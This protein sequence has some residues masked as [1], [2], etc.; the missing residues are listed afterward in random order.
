MAF[1]ETVSAGVPLLKSS[2]IPMRH[3]FT[4]RLGGVSEGY[5]ASLNLGEH[6]GDDPECVRENYRRLAAAL[7]FDLH[8]LVYTKQLHGNIVQ[9]VTSAD[10][11]E[12][13]TPL[14]TERDGICTAEPDLPLICYT[15]DC[16]PIL[17]CEPERNLAAAVHSGW[18]S[19]VRDIARSAVGALAS[20]GAEPEKLRAAIGP[21]IGKCCF[22]VGSDVADAMRA[23]LGSEAG[24][25]LSPRPDGKFLAD[26]R[27]ASKLRLMQLGLR[28]ENIDVSDECTMCSPEK[29]WSHRVTKGLRGSQAAVIIP[30]RR[31]RD[32]I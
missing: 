23:W 9:I 29:Y 7:D 1:Y 27:G 20:L 5:C 14:E 11:R 25:F 10:S 15:A 6:R 26:L 4:T 30:D 22:E 24:S 13:F 21:A 31:V 2:L 16:V 19:T 32:A 28:E 12:L 17:L 18:R 8:R 3:G